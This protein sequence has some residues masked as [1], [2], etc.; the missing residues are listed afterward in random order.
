MKMREDNQRFVVNSSPYSTN[1]SESSR[2]SSNLS[3]MKTL[4]SNGEET[5]DSGI[6]SLR[7]TPKKSHHKSKSN[8]SGQFRPVV[9]N[10]QT[11]EVNYNEKL[12]VLVL[13]QNEKNVDKIESLLDYEYDLYN[14]RKPGENLQKISVVTPKAKLIHI[15]HDQV[16]KEKRE[17]YNYKNRNSNSAFVDP[18][19]RPDLNKPR[20]AKS[21]NVRRSKSKRVFRCISRANPKNNLKNLDRTKSISEQLK[22]IKISEEKPKPKRVILNKDDIIKSA[23]RLSHKSMVN[24]P[25]REEKRNSKK[26]M[27]ADEIEKS[28]LRLSRLPRKK[29]EPERFKTVH[30]GIVLSDAQ[31]EKAST[32]LYASRCNLTYCY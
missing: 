8:K 22:T 25:Y 26:Y 27:T 5:S 9:V 29:S 12:D 3:F 23:Q 30:D 13:L 14:F 16:D 4:L 7:S 18:L 2:R 32:R 31:I 24:L 17:K 20:R 19:D 15:D 6:N 1:S 10:T 11:S 28:A 21:L